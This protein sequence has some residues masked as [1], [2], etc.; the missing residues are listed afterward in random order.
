[1]LT[2]TR[3]MCMSTDSQISD[4]KLDNF[5]NI[6]DDFHEDLPVRGSFGKPA[7][8]DKVK[9]EY[10]ACREGVCLIDMSTFTKFELRVG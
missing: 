6:P 5:P 4:F 8:F 3:A 7:W 10:W 1:M 9:S 2:C